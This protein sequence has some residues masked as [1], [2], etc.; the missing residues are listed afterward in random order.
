M[1]LFKWFERKLFTGD[2][3]EDYG[4]FQDERKGIARIRTR[5]LLCRRKGKLTLV[6]R[7]TGTAVLGASVYYSMLEITPES[8]A[9]LEGMVASVKR[10]LQTNTPPKLLS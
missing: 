1:S 4:E 9:R 8:A 6:F 5:L 10:H 2:I 7:T 3:L